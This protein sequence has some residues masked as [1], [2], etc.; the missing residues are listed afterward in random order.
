[1]SNSQTWPQNEPFENSKSE[2][3]KNPVAPE[4][5]SGRAAD[6][7]EIDAVACADDRRSVASDLDDVIGIG[8]RGYVRLLRRT[9]DIG[10]VHSVEAPHAI[11]AGDLRNWKNCPPQVW[12]ALWVPTV[13]GRSTATT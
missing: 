2:P 6:H 12:P 13:V 8:G 3:I 1:M 5:C 10:G 7:N 11:G 9:G 4:S